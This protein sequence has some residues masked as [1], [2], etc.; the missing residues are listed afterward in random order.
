MTPNDIYIPKSEFNNK[1]LM[2]V[3]YEYLD[4][5]NPMTWDE[6]YKIIKNEPKVIEILVKN[7]FHEKYFGE[8]I[9]IY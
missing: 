9:I 2:E 7:G 6:L 1:D 3:V 4:P 8:D 5:Y